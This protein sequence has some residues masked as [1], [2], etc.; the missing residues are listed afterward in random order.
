L[1]IGS[2]QTLSDHRE[3][4]AGADVLGLFQQIEGNVPDQFDGHEVLDNL[5]AHKAAAVDL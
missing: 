5:C 4:H 3:R 1:K 2:G